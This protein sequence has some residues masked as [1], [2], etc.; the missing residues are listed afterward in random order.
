M[1]HIF[2]K[3]DNTNDGILTYDNL[4]SI[5]SNL[6]SKK[7]KEIYN[8]VLVAYFGLGSNINEPCSFDEFC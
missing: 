8:L 3:L 4:I 7:E 2:N 5:D 6:L 1:R